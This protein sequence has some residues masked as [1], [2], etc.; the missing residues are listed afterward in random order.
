[1]RPDV[2]HVFEG[3]NKSATVYTRGKDGLRVTVYDYYTEHFN[4]AYFD[5]EQE[6]ENYAEDWVIKNE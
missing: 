6:A 4:E 1:M 3:G 2:L 5:N